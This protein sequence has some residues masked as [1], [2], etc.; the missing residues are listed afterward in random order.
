MPGAKRS[1]L[2][3]IAFLEPRHHCVKMRGPA[4]EVLAA[5]DLDKFDPRCADEPAEGAQRDHFILIA[6]NHLAGSVQLCGMLLH[7][8]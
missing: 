3:R 2:C 4:K 7:E 5:L 6:A 8:T 1:L